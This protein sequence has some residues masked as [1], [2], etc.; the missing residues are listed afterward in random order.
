MY[1]AEVLTP[2]LSLDP[3]RLWLMYDCFSL[4]RGSSFDC[5]G[6]LSPIFSTRRRRPA[7]AGSLLLL[8]FSHPLLFSFSLFLTGHKEG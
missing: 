7:F 5:Q 8:S 2:L 3:M 4:V 6:A 1:E